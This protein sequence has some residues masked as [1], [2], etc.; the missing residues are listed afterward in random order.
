MQVD[1]EPIEFQT[2]EAKIQ[3]Y[4]ADP[5][6][7][8]PCDLVNRYFHEARDVKSA[9]ELGDE[10]QRL[11]FDTRGRIFRPQGFDFNP[12]YGNAGTITMRRPYFYP[13]HST[14][15][16]IFVEERI[17][18]SQNLDSEAKSGLAQRLR[19]DAV[20]Y[21]LHPSDASRINDRLSR[22]HS[23]TEDKHA[24]SPD[25]TSLPWYKRLNPFRR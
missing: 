24:F 22:F 17:K 16:T 21:M 7:D 8:N 10:A 13:L 12:Q 19:E 6:A 15:F 18:A 5:T 4:L 11:L 20:I 1:R 2:V 9:K 3:A 14:L 23:L 25:V